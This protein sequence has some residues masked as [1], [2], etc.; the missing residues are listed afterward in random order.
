[1]R[2][3]HAGRRPLAALRSELVRTTTGPYGLIV[4][5]EISLGHEEAFDDLAART[6]I[7]ITAQET[8]TQH[9]F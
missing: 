2:A 5:F 6:I 8:P 1:M 4:R 3:D 7:A 9:G